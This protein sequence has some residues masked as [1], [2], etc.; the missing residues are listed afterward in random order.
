VTQN[1]LVAALRDCYD[2]LLRR[3]IVEL[4]LVRS[5]TLT[6][7]TDAP[8]A[9]IPGVP[10]RYV[11]HVILN[12]PGSDETANAQLIA[13]IENRLAGL[14]AISRSMVELLAPAFPILNARRS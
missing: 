3:N 10:P 1:D 4:N 8:G 5:A 12:A 7:D 14:P 2:P 13:Q 11:A 9:T 6:R